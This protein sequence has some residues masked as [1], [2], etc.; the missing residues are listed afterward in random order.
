MTRFDRNGAVIARSPQGDAAIQSRA[1]DRALL[2]KRPS[3]D[4]LR[5]F[6]PWIAT[7]PRASQMT[8]MTERDMRHA[9]SSAN[10]SEILQG[11]RMVDSD[12]GVA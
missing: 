4:G 2:K 6:A 9:R 11:W 12:R 3:P 10:D 7:A 5:P 1:T 8:V